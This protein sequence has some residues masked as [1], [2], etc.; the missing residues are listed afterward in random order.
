VPEI[1]RF[2]S[3]QTQNDDKEM[4]GNYNMGAGYAIYLPANQV[5]EVTKVAQQFGLQTWIA[6]SVEA[7]PKQ[8]VI[9]PL[10]ITFASDSLG[11]R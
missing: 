5:Y 10:D 4:Y 9:Q 7:G 6:G 2:I 11:V 1:F 8:V 3:E